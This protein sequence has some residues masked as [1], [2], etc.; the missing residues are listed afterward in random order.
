MSP[1]L[2][3]VPNFSTADPNTVAAL[4]DAA[5][6]PGAAVLHTDSSA[7]AARTVIT[8]AGAPEAVVE[9]A[10]RATAAAA[11]HIDMRA[12]TG[13]HPRIGATDVC[14]L[15]PLLGLSREEAVAH[16]DTLARRVGSELGIPVYL[17]EHSAAAA[18]RIA[19]PDIRRGQYEGFAQKMM[20]SEWAPDYGPPT[21]NPAAG[22]TVIGARDI[23]VAFNIALD[24]TDAAAAARIAARLRSSGFRTK[25]ADGST[26]CT[27]GLLQ[28]ARAIGWY[29]ADYG[30]A[31]VSF[32]LLD[33]RSA[34]PLKAYNACAA[35]AAL[36]GLRITGAEIIGLVPEACLVE[37]GTYGRMERGEDV[38]SISH[39]LLV[40][41]GIDVLGLSRLRPFNAGE[42][43]LEWALE[44]A[45]FF[46][47][48]T[49]L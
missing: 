13:I 27:P 25:A 42:Q 21:L 5:A 8:I 31:Q 16:A 7:A 37:A 18:H 10:F 3:C 43:V 36:E 22:A 44:R 35:L 45:G 38:S 23:L 39:S 30:A 14:P 33:Y 4:V 17:Y 11:R 26:I 15:V 1:L 46:E 40:H 2:E 28:G 48:R 41:E 9:A 19:L 12:Q 49:S 24:T 32:N 34:S 29:N 20:L 47:G 6:V